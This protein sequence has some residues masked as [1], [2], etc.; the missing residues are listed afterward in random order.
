[1]E[2]DS[3]LDKNCY[4]LEHDPPEINLFLADLLGISPVDEHHWPRQIGYLSYMPHYASKMWFVIAPT[5]VSIRSE[6][7]ITRVMPGI[8]YDIVKDAQTSCWISTRDELFSLYC[9]H[10]ES[11]ISPDTYCGR[12]YADIFIDDQ[13]IESYPVQRQHEAQIRS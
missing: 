6:R 2:R 12:D 4:P 3:V 9:V 1:M 5:R 13:K 7:N 11:V 8:L 10:Y